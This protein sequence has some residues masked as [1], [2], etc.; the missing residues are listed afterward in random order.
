[1]NTTQPRI[2]EARYRSYDQKRLL[3][4][5]QFAES[6]VDFDHDE[7]FRFD[8]VAYLSRYGTYH[9]EGNL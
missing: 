1:M 5:T 4:R 7:P 6:F 8:T 2:S 3:E 9:S